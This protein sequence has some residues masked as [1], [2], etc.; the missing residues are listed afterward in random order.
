MWSLSLDQNSHATHSVRK[1]TMF[2][3]LQNTHLDLTFITNVV[4]FCEIRLWLFVSWFGFQ[5]SYSPSF[6]GNRNCSL[7]LHRRMWLE[8]S[9]LSGLF[10]YCIDKMFYDKWK[11][12]TSLCNVT[13]PLQYPS[14]YS[15]FNHN[16]HLL[17]TKQTYSACGGW[18]QMC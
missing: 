15:D 16:Y 2:N 7:I 14:W 5:N 4:L 13:F 17:S 8:A 12:L 9:W 3:V 11:S 1:N 6:Y 18:A 10:T